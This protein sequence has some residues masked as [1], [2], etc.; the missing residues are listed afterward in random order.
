MRLALLLLAVTITACTTVT[1][2]ERAALQTT[3]A[4]SRANII[5]TQARPAIRACVGYASGR[6]FDA[7]PLRQ[8][9][10]TGPNNAVAGV[11]Y[12]APDLF[13]AL[14]ENRGLCRMSWIGDASP[15]STTNALREILSSAGF[16]Q[17]GQSDGRDVFYSNGTV[18]LSAA[19]VLTTVSG[20]QSI[21]VIL[22]RR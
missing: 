6:P 1:P 19:S 21:D 9:G 15:V 3:A 18:T 17:T 20:T 10:F 4:E 12:R 2:E 16:S 11:S 5:Q 14:N 13:V 22:K 8:A 7:A